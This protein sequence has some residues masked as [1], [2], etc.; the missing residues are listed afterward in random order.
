MSSNT[1]NAN[2][3]PVEVTEDAN[4]VS[5]GTIFA[6]INSSQVFRRGKQIVVCVVE[7]LQQLGA[8]SAGIREALLLAGLCD[9]LCF[10]F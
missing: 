7:D 10:L 5:A 4:N 1:S 9:K 6:E 2:Q 3:V 8:Q